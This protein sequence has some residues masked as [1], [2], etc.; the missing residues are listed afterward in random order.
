LIGDSLKTICSE[1]YGFLSFSRLLPISKGVQIFMRKNLIYIFCG[2]G[3]WVKLLP[4]LTRIFLLL[5]LCLPGVSP[6][7]TV[8]LSG[9]VVD[10]TN[11]PIQGAAVTLYTRN[12]V[13]TVTD[14]SGAF[15]LAGDAVVL[16][17][18]GVRPYR[19]NRSNRYLSTMLAGPGTRIRMRVY[20]LNGGKAWERDIGW[21]GNGSSGFHS[22]QTG[23]ASGLYL[24]TV[25]YGG[26]RV[27]LRYVLHS[28]RFCPSNLFANAG[29]GG[30]G[31]SRTTAGEFSDI[32]V[33]SADGR[34][35]V[36]RAV[37][38]P[39]ESAIIIKLMPLGV[40][41]IT[42]TI[43]VFTGSGGIG[44]ITTYGSVADPEYSQG[45]A[46]NYGAT[47][48]RYYAAIN[49]NQIPGDGQGNWQGGRCCGRC[50]RVRVR[51]A[52]GEERI[53]VVRIVDRC[54][55]AQCGIDLGGAPAGVIMRDQPGRYAG[56][57]EWVNC[58]DYEGVSD[59]PASMYIKE[60]SNEWWSLAQIR[61]GPGSVS[62]LR[63]RKVNS[64]DWRSLDW[65]TEAENF[66][67]IP[68]DVLQD[69]AKW[70]IEALWD[71]GTRGSLR[72]PGKGLAIADTLYTLQ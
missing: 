68:A 34:Q 8:R 62:E 61:N 37:L 42:P 7:E 72:I 57:W 66:F 31:L 2:R 50:A 4:V 54:A 14:A 67:R 69:S 41:Y 11:K 43:P 20:D 22:V 9:T 32:L 40:G 70:D 29:S 28:N 27:V 59:G 24:V 39:E 56:E 18:P 38:E 47:K 53:V 60:G 51:V 55:D 36:R 64:D 17:S 13:K 23:L 5:V 65:A 21:N 30:N 46:C 71:T 19:G 12:S 33:V 3:C 63:V 26:Q 58:D 35:T 48:L 45:G 49:V 6:A 16:V 10:E 52:T 25:E 1:F 15:E 44:D